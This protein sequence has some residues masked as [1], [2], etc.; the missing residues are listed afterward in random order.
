M[1]ITPQIQKQAAQL[2]DSIN[3]HNYYYYVLDD[4]KL[5]DSEY[6][7]LMRELLALEKEYPELITPDSPT[8]RVG[9]SPLSSFS[10][11]AHAIPMLSLGNAFDDDE[12]HGF[13]KR[14]R[15]QLDIDNIEYAVELKLDGLA[16][17]LRYENGLLVTGA[18]RGDGHRGEDVTQN[19]KTIKSIPLRLLGDDFPKVLEVRGEVF[20]PKAGFKKY[21]EQKLADGKKLSSNPRNAAAGSLRQLDASRTASRPLSFI[22]YA[23]GE[24][25]GG[26]LPSSHSEILRRLQ[27]WGLPISK[28]SE[29]VQGS[30]ACLDYYY[31]ILAQRD[32]LPFDIDGVVYK[33]NQISQQESLGFVSRA[34]RWAIAHKFPA[35]EVLTQVLDIDVQVG[36][37]GALTPVARLAPVNVA[38][39][40]VTNA[41]LHNQDEIKRKD[42]RVGDTV[43]VRRAGDVIP[44]VVSVL[45]DKRPENTQ[46]YVLPN[47]CPVCSAEVARVVGEAVVRCTGGLF[48]AAQRKQALQ[49]FASRRAMEIDGLGEKLVEQ[50]IDRDLVK[51]IADI[52]ILKHEQWTSLERMGKK[53]A[54]KILKALDKSKSTTLARFLYALGIR[55]VGENTSK[56]LAKH[57]VSLDKIMQ[58]DEKDLEKLPDI[59]PV[60]AQSVVAFFKES[61]NLEVI[62]SFKSAGVHWDETEVEADKNKS[63]VQDQALAGQIFVLTG[64]LMSMPRNTAKARLEALGAKVSGSV[65]KKTTCVVAGEKA[66]SKLT[67]AQN[68]GV[69]VIDEEEFVALLE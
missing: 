23:I 19:V 60:V 12:V 67:K 38:G 66:G 18:T 9:A 47:K 52:Y 35:E 2:R 6:D 16:V 30:R 34:P 21:N 31:K 43:I 51:S 62:Q 28:Y 65:S 56:I 24:V 45:L 4:P 7:R 37:T 27:V 13:D 53:S 58:A 57:F 59:G 50:L 39:V 46:A 26:V 22:S 29:V 10:E 3:K 54:D 41:T 1:K 55:E 17:S 33:V 68:L 32:S 40:V 64:T 14:A 11:V 8:Q 49:H 5:P 61:H 69:K 48:C 44:E 15:K 25:E 42:V 63:E 36:R 20:M